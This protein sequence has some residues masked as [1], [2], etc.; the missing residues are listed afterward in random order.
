[1]DREDK[2]TEQSKT[3]WFI[4][5]DC[6]Q[7]NNRSFFTLA[8]H[9]LCPRCRQH[10]KAEKGETL[11]AELLATIKDCCSKKPG[12]ITRELPILE[13]IFRVFLANGNQPLNLEELA[14]QLSKG[15]GGNAYR[16]SVEVLSRLLKSDKYYGL[17]QI[18]A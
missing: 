18:T 14:K 17:R 5:L 8:R 10:L 9:C 2:N 11:V 16:T 3:R 13:S 12:F 7:P 15:R 4:D 6:Y 1:M